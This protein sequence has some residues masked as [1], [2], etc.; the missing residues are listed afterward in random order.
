MSSGDIKDALP[1]NI[2]SGFVA[3][4]GR[5]NVGKSTLLNLLVGEKV[6]ITSPRPQ[7]TR[8]RV[9]GIM[10]RSGIQV[11]F[12]DTPGIMR[13][14]SRLNKFMIN[15]SLKAGMECDL[16]IFMTDAER[17]NYDSDRYALERL[18]GKKVPRLLLINKIDAVKKPE[19]L[20]QIAELIKIAQFDEVFPISARTG[21]GVEAMVSKMVEYLPEG[22]Q[23]YPAEMKTDQ[24]ERFYIGEIIREK[25]FRALQ[26]ELPY[27]TAVAIELVEDRENGATYIM[28]S[29]FVERDSQKG[30]VIGK[31]GSMLKK[32]GTM[33]REELEFRFGAKVFLELRVKVKEKWTV[34][35]ASLGDLGY[36]DKE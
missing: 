34:N 24:P 17:P 8:N 29:I 23:F 30:I 14:R 22:P 3:L 9:M 12:M 15:Q 11:V 13:E 4:A 5:P 2:K 25:A 16:L 27:S 21:E 10:T 7:T 31:G 20:A 32:I 36:V 33:A 6:S 28:G 1:A 35:P 18:G 19:L 26:Q